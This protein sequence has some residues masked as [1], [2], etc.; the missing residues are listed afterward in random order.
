[1]QPP[2]QQPRPAESRWFLRPSRYGLTLANG[3]TAIRIVL[4]PFIALAL[5]NQR[6][7]QA[8]W[9]MIAAGA[10]DAVD[11]YIARAFG[12]KSLVGA[13]LDPMADKL[14]LLTTLG[15]LTYANHLPAWLMLLVLARDIAIVATVA[16]FT[17]MKRV[18]L[19][20]Q[21]LFI[22]KLTTFGQVLLV[23]VVVANLAFE[24]EWHT[25]VMGLIWGVAAVTAA[26]WVAYF[27]EGLRA[28]RTAEP[29][30]SA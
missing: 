11:G 21:P 29:R 12:H 26:S 30:P 10:S 15:I 25:L 6:F 18:D 7:D 20:M 1:M 23:L 28:L 2:Q 16:A 14:L 17:L 27:L 4:V 22:S 3:V 8:F 9:M 5:L 19:R 24:L 13:Y